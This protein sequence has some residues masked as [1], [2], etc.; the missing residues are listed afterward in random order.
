MTVLKTLKIKFLS[1][2]K[3]ESNKITYIKFSKLKLYLNYFFKK[4]FIS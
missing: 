4:R 2:Y 1:Q 3:K